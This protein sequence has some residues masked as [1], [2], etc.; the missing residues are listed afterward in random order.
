MKAR[1]LYERGI[2]F[3]FLYTQTLQVSDWNIGNAKEGKL[4]RQSLIGA[5]IIAKSKEVNRSGPTEKLKGTP[6]TS[7]MSTI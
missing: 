4:S 2:M 5:W 1:S 7:H 3:I 6:G